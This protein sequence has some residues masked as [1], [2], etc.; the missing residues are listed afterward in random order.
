MNDMERLFLIVVATLACPLVIPVLLGNKED[1]H[2]V[3]E[4]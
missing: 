4:S 2:E 3:S 1:E